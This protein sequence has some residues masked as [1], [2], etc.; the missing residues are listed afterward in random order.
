MLNDAQV[1]NPR[2]YLRRIDGV[3]LRSPVNTVPKKFLSSRVNTR[4]VGK[5]LVN[6]LIY[7]FSDL[8]LQHHCCK[9]FK[10]RIILSVSQSAE[11]RSHFRQTC[12][13]CYKPSNFSLNATDCSSDWMLVK[14]L[15]RTHGLLQYF[16]IPFLSPDIKTTGICLYNGPLIAHPR[17]EG[18]LI[19]C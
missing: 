1:L 15:D 6:I 7:L 12:G 14:R 18:Q 2:K 5:Y 16:P 4:F 9:N 8:N 10:S 13:N 17:E 11:C 19:S 3:E